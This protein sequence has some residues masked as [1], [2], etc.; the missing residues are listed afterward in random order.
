MVFEKTLVT[1]V[2][3]IR[4]ARGAEDQYIQ[5]SVQEIKQ[6]LQSSNMQ[7]KSMAVL[8]LAYLNMLG[9]DIMWASFAIVD[10]MSRCEKM[11]LRRPA[12]LAAA[13]CFQEKNDL[14]LMLINHFKKSLMSGKKTPTELGIALSN[15]AV[16]CTPDMGRELIQD[17]CSLLSSNKPYLRKKVVLCMFRLFLRYPLALRTAFPK[18]KERLTDE[19]QGVLTACVNTFL[20]LTRKNARNYLILV[21]HFFTLLTQTNNNWLMIKLL[22]VFA[23]LCPLEP[24]LAGKLGSP[25]QDIL[26]TT[27]AKSVEFEVIRCITRVMSPPDLPVVKQAMEK[28][29]PF[30]FSSDRNLRYL[31]LEIVDEFLK[32]WTSVDHTQLPLPNELHETILEAIEEQDQTIRV[33][34]LS[35]LDK[36][37]SK[38][39]FPKIAEKLMQMSSN[40]HSG[41]DEYI[42]TLLTMG[43]QEQYELVEDFGWYILTLA[44]IA[45]KK[46]SE[47]SQLV[48]DQFCDICARVEGVRP[49]AVSVAQILLLGDG[50]SGNGIQNCAPAMVAAC[51]WV[52]G[53]YPSHIE[54]PYLKNIFDELLSKG[55]SSLPPTTQVT[56]L[57]AAIKILCKLG[58]ADDEKFAEYCNLLVEALGEL[59]MSPHVEVSERASL[60]FYLVEW[61]STRRQGLEGSYP[62][63]ELDVLSLG[64]QEAVTEPVGMDL[65]T[66]FFEEE[67]PPVV[68]E[69]S[70]QDA[71]ADLP[72]YQ[73][74]LKLIQQQQ[75]AQAAANNLPPGEGSLFMLKQNGQAEAAGVTSPPSPSKPVDPLAAMREKLQ[76]NK[77]QYSVLRKQKPAT[78]SQPGHEL[79]SDCV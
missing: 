13:F 14:G 31:G 44:D 33:V 23:Q 27:R 20:E 69:I 19:D 60:A 24:R 49:Y 48:A 25:L 32:R 55:Q 5:Q 29:R 38:E 77:Q 74:D 67:P 30:L 57:W 46:H 35:I 6:E 58:A 43:E 28:I 62:A 40:L 61:G 71:Y 45:K 70:A 16:I 39:S 42:K 66:P 56:C 68:E 8:K 15:L 2:K 79:S 72:N 51:A 59:V 26:Q 36:I 73:E 63:A 18:L 54:A 41:G 22:K 7:V 76:Q 4:G 53:E 1:M 9:Y 52:L 11:S 12:Y 64:D 47:H 37:V 3:G 50:T 10:C 65:D 21:P 34:A 78:A 17:L 75:A